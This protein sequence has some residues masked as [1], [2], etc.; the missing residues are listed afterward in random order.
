MKV[1]EFAGLVFLARDVAHSFHWNTR[2]YAQHVAL[3]AFYE[4]LP[5][6]IDS[7]VEAYQGKHGLMGPVELQ[8]AEKNNDI[9]EF[10][11]DQVEQ[12]EKGRYEFCDKSETAL[13]N[14]IDELVAHYLSAIYK[15]RFLS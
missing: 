2:S 4:A 8:R 6:S 11:E 7:F 3:Q 12:I 15:L 5:E 14:L 10:L 9:I 13:Q 1:T